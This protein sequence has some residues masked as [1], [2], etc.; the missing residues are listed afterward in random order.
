MC[1]KESGCRRA[2]VNS[3]AEINLKRRDRRKQTRA[4][5]AADNRP[6]T[7]AVSRVACVIFT[8]LSSVTALWINSRVLSWY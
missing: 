7:D 2:I 8:Q 3:T 1:V 4:S 6:R 5:Y